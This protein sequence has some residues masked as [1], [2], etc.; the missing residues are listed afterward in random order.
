MIYKTEE[1]AISLE[2]RICFLKCVFIGLNYLQKNPLNSCWQ[3]IRSFDE[4]HIQT[5]KYDCFKDFFFKVALLDDCRR[6]KSSQ[7]FQSFS[8]PDPHQNHT[9]RVLPE[10]QFHDTMSLEQCG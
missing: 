6:V 8:Q 9:Q 5:T 3:N 10:E 7:I 2:K 1:T 4:A